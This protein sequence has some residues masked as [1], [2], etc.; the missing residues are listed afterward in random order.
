[1]SFKLNNIVPI[2]IF[3]AIG[4]T[5]YFNTQIPAKSPSGNTVIKPELKYNI[6][7]E[8]SDAKDHDNKVT[9]KHLPSGDELHFMLWHDYILLPD[10][11]TAPPTHD[12][13]HGKQVPLWAIKQKRETY[14][15]DT[16]WDFGAYAGYLT[17]QTK[18]TN[19]KE[20]DVGIKISPVRIY[21]SFSPDILGSAQG[22]GLGV[23]FY[24]CP[25]KYGEI[26][27]HLGIG[28]SRFYTFDDDSQR[29]LFY[30]TF[31]TSF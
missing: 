22:V 20:L 10:G 6:V 2:L 8:S 16:G 31:S 18:G 28:Y 14:I 24:P 7:R 4:L 26:W 19:V 27:N 5:M 23:S 9:I 12:D 11:Q 29:N 1:M 15:F 17:G 30:V 21:K 13:G 25:E 3:G